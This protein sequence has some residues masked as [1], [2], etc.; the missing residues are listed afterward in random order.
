[1]AHVQWHVTI[2]LSRIPTHHTQILTPVQDPD[3]SHAK[4]CAV[5][6]YSREAFQQ[7]QQFLTPFQ[8]PNLS[9]TKSL[10][11]YRF[12]T[13]EIIA[14]RRAAPGQLRHFLM[15]VQAPSASHTNPYA[16]SGSLQ[17]E[18]FPTPGQASDNSHANPY[19][20][21]GSQSF[22]RTSLRL[23]R[24]PAIQSILYDWEASQQFYKFLTQ[25]I[26]IACDHRKGNDS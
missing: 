21:T 3:A 8:A 12:P 22:T 20:R 23:Y 7:C 16:C 6:P 15:Q 14:Y 2:H 17:F 26:L 5:D 24:F 1:M 18:Q 25:L 19:T 13:I 10:C 11:L 4:P 9:H